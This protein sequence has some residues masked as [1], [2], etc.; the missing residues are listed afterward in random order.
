MGGNLRSDSPVCR[1]IVIAFLDFL[2][3]VEPAPGVDLEGL[4]VARECL[5]E[6]FK[7]NQ[8][9]IDDGIEP[10]VLIDLFTSHE[11]G[12]QLKFKSVAAPAT[13]ENTSCTTSASQ[14]IESSNGLV[15]SNSEDQAGDLHLLGGVSKDELF[16]KFLAAL[17]KI[18]FLKTSPG[19]VDDPVQVAKA[20]QFFNDAL[21]E[22]E[23]SQGQMV[24]ISSLAE[25]LKSKGNQSM[26]L[27][28]Y[29]EAVELYTCAIALS[30]NNAVYYCNRA[31]AYTQLQRYS[32]AI[33]DC[34]KSIEIDPRY[35]KAYSRLGVAFYSQGNYIEALN[36]GFLKALQLDPS[37]NSVKESIRAAEQKLVE[38]FRQAEADRNTGPTRGQESAT[39]SAGS[40]NRSTPFA[41]LPIHASIPTNFAN[42]FRNMASAAQGNQAH[43]RRPGGNAEVPDEPGITMD[44]NVSLNIGE[45]PEQISDAFRFMMDMVSS[46][47][48]TQGDMPTGGD[49]T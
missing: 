9:S 34:L 8:S 29:S 33:E 24:N 18:N 41:S 6:V 4:D 38:Q 27:K 13:L 39:P 45:A 11:T 36:Q 17:D 5:E 43:E 32:E 20:I 35:S 10:G 1:R 22:L 12:E 42:I 25:T 28:L 31:A 15:T 40:A 30:E 14:Q 44:A 48:R 46:Q 2:K 21:T 23:N 26:Q 19:G 49:Q 7:L 3:S 47:Q 16:G 37:N